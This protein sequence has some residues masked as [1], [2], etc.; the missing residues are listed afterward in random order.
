MAKAKCKGGSTTRKGGTEVPH[1]KETTRLQ[2]GDGP[3]PRI[4]A[5]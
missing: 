1:S 3:S 4:S 2:Q 5:N